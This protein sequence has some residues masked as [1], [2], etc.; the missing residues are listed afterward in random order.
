MNKT[1]SL[2]TLCEHPRNF[3]VEVEILTSQP[4]R[5]SRKYA[6]ASHVNRNRQNRGMTSISFSSFAKPW[7]KFE[8]MILNAALYPISDG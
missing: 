3:S 6:S 5:F 4:S 2:Q 8:V 7:E 1:H